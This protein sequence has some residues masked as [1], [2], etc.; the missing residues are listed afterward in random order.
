[1][2][3]AIADLLTKGTR[4]PIINLRALNRFLGNESFK[5]EGLQIVRSLIQEGDF[6]IKLDLKDAYYALPIH[7]FHRKNLRFVYQNRTHEFQYL[8]FGHSSALRAFTKTLKP[9]V[10]VLRSLGIRIVIYI[11]DMLL[12]INGAVCCGQCLLRW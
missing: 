6:I 7:P 1:M 2:E 5:M 8:P 3:L 4:S 10:A 12:S 9:V 11:D